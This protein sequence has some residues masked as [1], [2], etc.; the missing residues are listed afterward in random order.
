MSVIH[1]PRLEDGVEEPTGE[2][3]GRLEREVGHL[4]ANG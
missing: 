1:I 4:L 2:E 3:R